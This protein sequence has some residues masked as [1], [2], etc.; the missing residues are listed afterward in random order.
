[1]LKTN[2]LWKAPPGLDQYWALDPP[3][4]WVLLVDETRSF[5]SEPRMSTAVISHTQ[6][7]QVNN[8]SAAV[9]AIRLCLTQ[10]KPFSVPNQ[11]HAFIGWQMNV[12][13]MSSSCYC[14]KSLN[15]AQAC[16]ARNKRFFCP[17][18]VNFNKC[19]GSWFLATGHFMTWITAA[20][21]MES[22][23]FSLLCC[24]LFRSAL[25]VSLAAPL[26]CLWIHRDLWNLP[27]ILL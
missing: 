16:W 26:C 9:T 10:R 23:R 25:G 20:D 1:M 6:P 2:Q 7:K 19:S 22:F 24:T 18:W 8:H 14:R 21:V 3:D 13:K 12:G 15:Q 4:I 17:K 27:E 11:V 5:L